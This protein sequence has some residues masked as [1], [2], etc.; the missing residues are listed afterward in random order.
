MKNIAV[1]IS[2]LVVALLMTTC[3]S[4]D[5][6]IEV[7]WDG[8]ECTVTGPTEL[9]V[10]N[11]S[12]ALIDLSDQEVELEVIILLEGKTLQE[13]LDE[14][15]EPGRWWPRPDWIVKS[16]QWMGPAKID[17]KG[18]E[19]WTFV[20]DK[21]GDYYVVVKIDLP[22]TNNIWFCTQPLVVEAPSE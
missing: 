9:P 18:R 15:G 19:L 5:E 2:L 10:G 3:A 11:H 7:T 16:P 8:N 14:Q 21:E 20:L 12:F 1:I 13:A 17:E 22:D 6:E 4:G